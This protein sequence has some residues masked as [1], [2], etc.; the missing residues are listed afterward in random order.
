MHKGPVCNVL[1]LKQHWFI[2][3]VEHFKKSSEALE[4]YTLF[5]RK[6][7]FLVLMFQRR[8]IFKLKRGFTALKPCVQLENVRLFMIMSRLLWICNKGSPSEKTIIISMKA[9]GPQCVNFSYWTAGLNPICTICNESQVCCHEKLLFNT[10]LVYD[11]WCKNSCSVQNRQ[12]P[13]SSLVC[14]SCLSP[15]S[16]EGL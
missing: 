7:G 1:E 15:L 12:Y 14:A 4:Q 2:A 16:V 13:R 9:T 6:N 5:W 11:S 3:L 8:W 10:A